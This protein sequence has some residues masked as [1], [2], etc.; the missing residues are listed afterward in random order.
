MNPSNS[1][2]NQTFADFEIVVVDDGLYRQQRS[3][4]TRMGIHVSGSFAT[5]ANLGVSLTRNDGVAVAQGE[6]IAILDSM[7]LLY[8]IVLKANRWPAWCGS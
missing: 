3:I 4:V 1:L 2:I 6:Y 5:T 7:M 8:P